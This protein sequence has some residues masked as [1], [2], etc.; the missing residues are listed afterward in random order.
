MAVS[1]EFLE[2]VSNDRDL[3]SEVE[4][5]TYDALGE[6]LKEK[7]LEEEAGRAMEAAMEKVAE[8]HGFEPADPDE[9]AIDELEGVSGGMKITVVKNPKSV[10]PL[11]KLIFKIKR[12]Q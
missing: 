1:K 11:L 6:L 4:R 3:E 8:A 9:L 12:E 10:A 7:G 2:A 5:A